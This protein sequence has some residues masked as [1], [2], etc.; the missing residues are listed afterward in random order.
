VLLV[1][2]THGVPFTLRASAFVP[3]RGWTPPE[4]LTTAD[5][6]TDISVTMDA[7]GRGVVAWA[8]PEGDRATV[9]SVR[10]AAETVRR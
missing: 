5:R 8:E 1:W 10:L 3:G 6:L 4:T 9:F 7:L 2:V